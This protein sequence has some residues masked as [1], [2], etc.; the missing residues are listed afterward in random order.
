MNNISL[1]SPV[2]LWVPVVDLR[3][4]IYSETDNNCTQII[5]SHTN[6]AERVFFKF[7]RDITMKYLALS[8][9][10]LS[11]ISF[12]ATAQQKNPPPPRNAEGGFVNDG[13]F[14]SE[15]VGFWGTE[16]KVSLERDNQNNVRIFA[17]A[18]IQE[19]SQSR[20]KTYNGVIKNSES[21][22]DNP[23]PRLFNW[24]LKVLVTELPACGGNGMPEKFYLIDIA[25]GKVETFNQKQA[26]RNGLFLKPIYPNDI[27]KDGK[28]ISDF[29]DFRLVK[30]GDLIGAVVYEDATKFFTGAETRILM[31]DYFGNLNEVKGKFVGKNGNGRWTSTGEGIRVTINMKFKDMMEGVPN[32]TADFEVNGTRYKVEWEHPDPS[33]FN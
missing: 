9:C 6:F 17:Q 1:C 16:S 8:A 22:Y 10:L 27:A 29:L 30:G 24:K 7:K 26:E 33:S 18:V 31:R 19:G 20:L 12:P 3:P 13:P 25:T 21:C 11:M 14:R 15:V 23:V 5:C 2:L 4:Q 32:G 28:T